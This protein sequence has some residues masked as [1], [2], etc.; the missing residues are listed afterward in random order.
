MSICRSTHVIACAAALVI[1]AGCSNSHERETATAEPA[2]TQ[3][4][5]TVGATGRMG[6]GSRGTSSAKVAEEKP[7]GGEPLTDAEIM[8]VADVV[9]MAEID[10]ALVA[11]RKANAPQIRDYAERVIADHRKAKAATAAFAQREGVAPVASSLGSEV[12]GQAAGVLESLRNKMSG[13]RF[14]RMYIETQL[15][16]HR[17]V[18]GLLDGKLIPNAQDERLETQ[19]LRLRAMVD[20]HL[21]QARNIELTL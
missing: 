13:E 10:Q 11:Q 21:T 8:G 3:G 19:L 18:I 15:R 4:D 14:D 16:Q 6:E 5:E 1:A 12:S 17:S 7:S 2:A 20:R 9:S